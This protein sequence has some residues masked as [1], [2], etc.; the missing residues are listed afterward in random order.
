MTYKTCLMGI[1]KIV[2]P[3]TV[4]FDGQEMVFSNGKEMTKHFFSKYFV[5]DSLDMTDGK[6]VITLVE[7]NGTDT[8]WC[9]EEQVS[10]F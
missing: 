4:N 6:I 9:G 1:D 7:Q 3:V 10:F 8:T 2:C 5:V